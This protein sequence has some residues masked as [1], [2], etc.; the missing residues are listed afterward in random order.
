MNHDNDNRADLLYGAKAI[1]EY[2]QLTCA[3]VYHLVA[4]KRIPV[5]KIGGKVAARRATLSAWLAE[6]EQAGRAAA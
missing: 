6:Q 5:F 1:A 4:E 3:V 2:L